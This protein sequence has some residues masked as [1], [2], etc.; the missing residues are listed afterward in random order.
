MAPARP[1]QPASRQ[2]HEPAHHP[3]RR[4]RLVRAAVA[5]ATLG[6]P[7]M[8]LALVVRTEVT[9]VLSFDESAIRAA[10]DLTRSEPALRRALL[11]WQEAFRAGWVNLAVT[12]VCVWVWRRH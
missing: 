3:G 4:H 7:F 6:L 12:L 5:A 2:A 9:P 8:I 11:A 1:R 10:T